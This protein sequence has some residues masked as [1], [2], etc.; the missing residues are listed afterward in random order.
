MGSMKKRA[1]L[2]A[3]LIGLSI[4]DPSYGAAQTRLRT[5]IELSGETA[6]IPAS[7]VIPNFTTSTPYGIGY[8]EYVPPHRSFADRAAEVQST[9]GGLCH[10]GRIPGSR[11]EIA[12]SCPAER[13][14]QDRI[15]AWRDFYKGKVKAPIPNGSE[16]YLVHDGRW[17]YPVVERVLKNGDELKNPLSLSLSPACAFPNPARGER[18]T[19]LCARSIPVQVPPFAA[20]IEGSDVILTRL[21]SA[22]ASAYLTF[23]AQGREVARV[24]VRVEAPVVVSPQPPSTQSPQAPQPVAHVCSFDGRTFGARQTVTVFSADSVPAGGACTGIQLE[25]RKPD[26]KKPF[27]AWYR[28]RQPFN[29][30]GYFPSCGVGAL[31]C[32]PGQVSVNYKYIDKDLD[33]HYAPAPL[34]PGKD[35]ASVCLLQGTR[36]PYLDP[37]TRTWYA[38]TTGGSGEDARCDGDVR[39]QVYVDLP[40]YWADRDLDGYL[41]E[42]VTPVKGC[43]GRPTATNYLGYLQTP[44]QPSMRIMARAPAGATEPQSTDGDPTKPARPNA[45]GPNPQGPNPSGEGSK[46]CCVCLYEAKPENQGENC[47]FATDCGTWLH[48]QSGCSIS[49]THD[50]ANLVSTG[51]PLKEFLT[52]VCGGVD[53]VAVNFIRHGCPEM[54]DDPF[55]CAGVFADISGAETVSLTDDACLVFDQLDKAEAA[56]EKLRER[57]REMGSEATV[58]VTSNQNVTENNIGPGNSYCSPVTFTV[59]ASGVTVDLHPCHQPG[60]SCTVDSQTFDKWR[61]KDD[62]GKARTM[63]CVGSSSENEYGLV[64]PGRWEYKY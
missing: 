11:F 36:L 40:R 18:I 54:V 3:V 20:K 7:E 58:H 64:G 10:V 48:E 45:P 57:L 39:G 31:P 37:V 5:S 46:K 52:T 4:F 35:F 8:L 53:E 43:I 47:Q 55:H 33:G 62:D 13:G 25:C 63:V 26:P 34:A 56:A 12:Q 59:C 29:P 1:I 15:K 9:L 42:Y 38:M 27:V 32:P 60:S 21:Q 61:C 19:E 2:T 28:G 6:R 30:S 16:V 51:E 49:A 23:S 14:K 50:F 44:G 41:A 24:A 22:P 17:F